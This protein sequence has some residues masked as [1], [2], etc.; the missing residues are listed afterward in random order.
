[1]QIKIGK[2]ELDEWYH[3]EIANS[4]VRHISN[5]SRGVGAVVIGKSLFEPNVWTISFRGELKD[6][7]PIYQKQGDVVLDMPIDI[8]SDQQA[9][10]VQQHIDQFLLRISKLISFT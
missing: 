7:D 1:M 9:K 6:L 2:I 10:I 8:G 3:Y 4:W 5:A